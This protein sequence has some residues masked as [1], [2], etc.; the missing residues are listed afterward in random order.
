[1]KKKI[2]FISIILILI[3][4]FYIL[5]NDENQEIILNSNAEEVG[6]EVIEE[7]FCYVDIKGEVVKP[8]VYECVNNDKVIDI[9]NK[10]GGLTKEGNTKLINLSKKVHNEMLILIYSNKQIEN[11]NKRLNEPTVIEI[12]KEIEK[13]C[14]CPDTVNE[15][16]EFTDNVEVENI[17]NEE[18][19]TNAAEKININTANKEE[20]MNLPKIGEAKATSIIAYREDA[21][22]QNI[23]EIKNVSGIGDALFDEIKDLIEV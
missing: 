9:I 20:L 17:V 4:M 3:T 22:F 21:L 10:A 23:E 2:I 19:G 6:E 7:E 15:A 8:G 14:I 13:E 1:M 16:C 18:E 11:A 5:L 12:I